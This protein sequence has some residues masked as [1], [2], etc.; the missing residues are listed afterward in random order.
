M[1]QQH[2]ERIEEAREKKRLSVMAAD[3]ATGLSFYIYG[4]RDEETAGLLRSGIDFCEL[5]IKGS[6]CKVE[7]RILPSEFQSCMAVSS[8]RETMPEDFTDFVRELI[9][10]GKSLIEE[11][12]RVIETRSGAEVAVERAKKIRKMFLDASA[13]YLADAS[14]ILSSGLTQGTSE[15]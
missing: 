9:T 2:Y 5:M 6:G 11:I 10:E 7:R 3:A 8:L 14:S 13:P 1:Y 4:R 12:L 15:L